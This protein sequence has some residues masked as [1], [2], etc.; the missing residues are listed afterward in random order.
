MFTQ[1]LPDVILRRSFTR[2]STVL[3]VIEG[4]GTRLPLGQLH[5]LS[6]VPKPPSSLGTRLH[7]LH[8]L[9]VL[10]VTISSREDDLAR[11]LEEL[12]LVDDKEQKQKQSEQL[13]K[14]ETPASDNKSGAE[15]QPKEAGKSGGGKK[16]KKK[17]KNEAW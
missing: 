11:E 10:H 4:L 5:Q 6:L 14:Q 3:A 17:K 16:G 1:R 2:L 13:D 15:E 8:L 9:N 7:L 12:E